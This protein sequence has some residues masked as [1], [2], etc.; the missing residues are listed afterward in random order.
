M[1]SILMNLNLMSKYNT[2]DDVVLT[3]CLKKQDRGVFEEIYRRYWK[4]LYLAAFKRIGS[5]EVCEEIVQDIFTSLWINSSNAVIKNLSAY[6]FTATRY[7]VINYIQQEMVRKNSWA[8]KSVVDNS[9]EE[10]VYLHDLNDALENEIRK[11]RSRCQMVYKLSYQNNLS[12]K[13]VAQQLGIS[14]KTV[15]NQLTKAMKTLRINL[16]HFTYLM[17]TALF[18]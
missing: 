3:E 17:V 13:Q 9:T 11:L 7:K 2:Y 14:E 16:K 6:L 18:L 8:G 12:I 15:E 5:C 1:F 10:V 4:R